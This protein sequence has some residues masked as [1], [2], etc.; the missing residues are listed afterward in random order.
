MAAASNHSTLLSLIIILHSFSS[1]AYAAPVLSPF[2]S[3]PLAPRSNAFVTTNPLNGSI[4]VLDSN[5]KQVIPQV[6][7]TDGGGAEGTLALPAILWIVVCAT[8]GFPL[9]SAGVRGWRLTT[10]AAVSLAL[11]VCAWAAFINTVSAPGIPDLPLTLI[12]LAFMLVGLVLGFLPIMRLGAI[13]ILGII[14]GL[15]IGI[16]IVIVKDNLLL[17]QPSLFAVNWVIVAV[18]AALGGAVIPFKQRIGIL[19]GSASAGSFLIGLGVDLLTNR[20]DGW[21]RGLR[22]LFDQN[23]SHL[24]DLHTGFNM[25]ISSQIIIA[26]S[27]SLIPPAAYFQHR[28]FPQPFNRNRPESFVLEDEAETAFQKTISG[29]IVPKSRFSH[30]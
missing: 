30:F 2:I 9:L 16:R 19:V 15:A 26:V 22:F 29:L 8:F 21:S 27:L 1:S 20:Q 10:A 4:E 3:F 17:S 23:D 14:G 7:A 6:P 24:A 5:T 25:P 13:T 18:C 12:V 28:V 11:G